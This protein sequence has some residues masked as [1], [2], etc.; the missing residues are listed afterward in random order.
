MRNSILSTIESMGVR[1]RLHQGKLQV[2]E[3]QPGAKLRAWPEIIRYSN[4]LKTELAQSANRLPYIDKHKNLVIPFNSPE[5][6]HW[7]AGGQSIS[8][9]L[10][11]LRV[12][13]NI[14]SRYSALPYPL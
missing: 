1:V 3:L 10:M 4:E 11:E 8:E 6:Y 2:R 14:W 5:K 7:W 9:T 12:P 13:K